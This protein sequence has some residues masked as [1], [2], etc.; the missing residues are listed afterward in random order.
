[1][2]HSPI[3]VGEVL[4]EIF[5]HEKYNCVLLKTTSGKYCVVYCYDAKIKLLEKPSEKEITTM[6][7]HPIM[8]IDITDDDVEDKYHSIFI[9]SIGFEA[10][11]FLWAEESYSPHGI[12]FKKITE[13]GYNIWKM[14]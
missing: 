6:L 14:P 5:V 1:M 4:E 2:H 3:A 11:Y 13:H 10:I 8:E 7:G 12:T 9:I